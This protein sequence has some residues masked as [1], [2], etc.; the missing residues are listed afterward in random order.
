MQPFSIG[1]SSRVTL[2]YRFP[3][4][5]PNKLFVLQFKHPLPRFLYVALKGRRIATARCYGGDTW[6]E[7]K[8]RGDP[9][10]FHLFFPPSPPPLNP[11]FSTARGIH[12]SLR[13][14]NLIRELLENVAYFYWEIQRSL[15]LIV[16]GRRHIE[17][18]RASEQAS[19][20]AHFSSVCFA[21]LQ[22]LIIMAFP[23]RIFPHRLLVARPDIRK[24]IQAENIRNVGYQF[25]SVRLQRN[26]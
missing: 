7:R 10:F 1:V 9:T 22:R 26:K 2:S 21:S 23:Q 8:R 18:A 20:S 5:L 12:E 15:Y 17:F 11:L 4:M 3:H 25:L 24:S 14:V 13:I 6:Q 16:N 19:F